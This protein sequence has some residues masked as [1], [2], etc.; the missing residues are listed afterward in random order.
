MKN[1]PYPTAV[2]ATSKILPLIA[3]ADFYDAWG[4]ELEDSGRSALEYFITA[5]TRSPPWVEMAM[6]LRNRVVAS[7]G[8]KN[9]G[10]LS[11]IE[12]KPLEQYQLGD[13][14][15]I[16]TLF[17]QTFEE[18]LL[19]DRDRHLDVTLSV[20]RS[21]VTSGQSVSLTLST[22]VHT[23]NSLGKLYMLPVKPMHKII[24]PAVLARLSL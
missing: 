11:A 17:E 13:R 6:R 1:Y 8:L 21:P 19:G 16:F 12:Q 3:Q 20:Q 10:T 2:P 23:H 9:L 4:I 14:V 15:G 18:V 5:A 22:V 24:A 7:V